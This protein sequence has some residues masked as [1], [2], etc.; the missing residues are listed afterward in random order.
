MISVLYHLRMNHTS[1]CRHS[2]TLA[3]QH[4][5]CRRLEQSS[6]HHGHSTCLIR[7]RARVSSSLLCPC[8]LFSCWPTHTYLPSLSMNTRGDSL[9]TLAL[10]IKNRFGCASRTY[11]HLL[12]KWMF[13][14]YRPTNARVENILFSKSLSQNKN[15]D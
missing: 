1:E 2:T 7:S 5:D 15:Y 10:Q 14:Y 6:E 8:S 12:S 4:C 9:S 13:V 3:S 11:S